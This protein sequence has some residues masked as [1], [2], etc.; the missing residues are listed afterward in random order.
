MNEK[1]MLT[2]LLQVGRDMRYWQKRYFQ[3]RNR[4]DHATRTA[5]LAEAK[6]AEAKLD[7]YLYNFQLLME[8]KK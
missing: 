8:V 3:E 7:S 6:K 4:A 2:K 1:E 5:I